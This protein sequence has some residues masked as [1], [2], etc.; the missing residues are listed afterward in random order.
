VI[1]WCDATEG[2]P[3]IKSG[4]PRD[5]MVLEHLGLV[6]A[7]AARI[8]RSLPMAVDLSDLFQAGVVGLLSAL[9]QY[10]ASKNANFDGYAKD[11][12]RAAI[13]ACLRQFEWTSPDMGKRHGQR[14]RLA[15][16]AVTDRVQ[17]QSDTET[18]E[19]LASRMNSRTGIRMR[20][21]PLGAA[22]GFSFPHRRGHATSDAAEA[23]ESR[24]DRIC[25]RNELRH[26]MAKAIE[27]LPNRHQKVLILS[28]V[29]EMS[30]EQIGGLFGV[31]SSRISQ[32]RRKATRKMWTE[33]RSGGFVPCVPSV[34]VRAGRA[35]HEGKQ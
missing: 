8:S 23:P 12:I 11:R 29:D 14:D 32:I 15:S 2:L 31:C 33:L 24:P 3:A 1:T 25:E 7:I 34:M 21:E 35:T 18:G 27:R 5:G 19:Q 4:S 26:A 28:Y 22:G 13:I 30:L 16:D 6:R 17:D 9:E 20:P 10:D